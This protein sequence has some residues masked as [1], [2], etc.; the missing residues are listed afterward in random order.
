MQQ[1][2]KTWA[3]LRVRD[4]LFVA[5]GIFSTVLMVVYMAYGC[6]LYSRMMKGP[7]KAT[8]LTFSRR[9]E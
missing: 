3:D 1:D 5:W 6:V 9:A 4:K 2:L 8:E 7:V